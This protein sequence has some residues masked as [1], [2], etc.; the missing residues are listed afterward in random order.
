LEWVEDSSNA[1]VKYTRNAIRH[2]LLPVIERIFPGA[3]DNMVRNLARFRDVEFLYHRAL[4]K[5]LGKL[6]VEEKGEWKVPVEKLRLA[7]PRNT[8]TWELFRPFG[9]TPHQVDEI[10]SLM[11][12][13]SGRFILSATHRLLK[14]RN[15]FIVS[16][17][18]LPVTGTWLIERGQQELS[19]PAGV[20]RIRTEEGMGQ[21]S[22][23]DR[24]ACLDARDIRFPLLVRPWRNGDYFYPLGMRKKK[25]LARFL[26]DLKMSKNDKEKVWVVESD[27]R[28]LWVIGL[29]IDDR[30]K[31]GESTSSHLMFRFIP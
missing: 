25:K 22:S 13:A 18:Q 3:G 19:F 26:I 10:Q 29:R 4:Q 30:F 31:V 15:W 14:N 12:S 28:I 23:D 7:V 6:M 17:L 8:I 11:D 21:F 16:P 24:E 1:E 5:E 2:D 27:R 20:L 9:F